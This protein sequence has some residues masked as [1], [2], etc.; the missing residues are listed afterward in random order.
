M[1]AYER[2]LITGAEGLLGRHLRAKVSEKCHVAARGRS[3]LDIAD[4]ASVERTCE[5]ERPGLIHQLRGAR[6][7][8]VHT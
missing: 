6:R 1:R 2:V 4:T 8:G 3:T 7:G 5:R